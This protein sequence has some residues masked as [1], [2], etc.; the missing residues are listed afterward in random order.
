MTQRL[1]RSRTN[2]MVA[3]VCGGLG[4]YLKLDATL[5]RIVFVLLTVGGGF[6]VP[7]YLILWIVVPYPPAESA[8]GGQ[9]AAEP[10]GAQDLAER[11][12]ALG[13]E[14]QRALHQADPKTLLVIG[15][16]LILAGVVS[17]LDRFDLPWLHWF[18]FGNLWPV[19]LILAGLAI[20]W[21]RA[22]NR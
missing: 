8:E 20:I 5:L 19:L 17:L 4:E 11:T 14:A 12:R 16:L 3:G 21:R 2:Q 22:Q 18:N 13:D 10:T 9:T 6:G 1:Y 7:L 15:G